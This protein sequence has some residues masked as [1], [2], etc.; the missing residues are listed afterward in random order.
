MRV[1]GLPL[2]LWNREV[3]KKIGDCY[4]GFVAV[5]ESTVALKELQWARVLVKSDGT[6]W[7]SFLQVV[8]DNTYFALQLWWEVLPRVFE[9]LPTIKNGLGKEPVAWEEERGTPCAGRVGKQM[10]PNEQLAKGVVS[11]EDG[12][13]LYRTDMEAHFSDLMS[14]KGVEANKT[15]RWQQSDWRINSKDGPAA[16]VKGI[17][18]WDVEFQ[19]EMRPIVE[20]LFRSIE[21]GG[22]SHLSPTTF[23]LDTNIQRR[24]IK[25]G[26]SR[27]M[28]DG[29]LPQSG[30]LQKTHIKSC[31]E[32]GQP[33]LES[34]KGP[35]V[36]RPTVEN[37]HEARACGG[38]REEIGGTLDGAVFGL[39]QGRPIVE[40]LF[41][42]I[43]VGG[44]SHLSPISFRLD[45]NIQRRAIVEG[46]FRS[47]EAGGPS[48]LSPITFRLD[49]NIL[50][51][52][53]KEGH[54]RS[55]EDGGLPQSD[56]L[57][58]THLKSCVEVGRPTLESQKGPKVGRPT[59]EDPHEARACGGCREEIG[60][61]PDKAV[62]GLQ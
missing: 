17:L 6:E 61:T 22:P 19:V 53:I 40:G 8:I 28:E 43:K 24:P 30:P 20:G 12:E 26:H 3:F 23:R 5:D 2:H 54:S 47:I 48:Y 21:A 42:S 32:V 14:T 31:M 34:Q 57:P 33:T 37:P 55:M 38:C 11:S 39:Q 18:G 36:G 10:Q 46:L 7:P 52:P 41:R 9:V 4:G 13:N 56:S 1:M 60:G 49:T 62:F 50:R 29:G 59:V 35:A 15:K 45:T 58:K 16:K 25:E 44:P 51:R 27:S